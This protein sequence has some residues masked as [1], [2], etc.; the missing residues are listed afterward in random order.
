MGSGYWPGEKRKVCLKIQFQFTLRDFKV[1]TS[2]ADEG[3]KIF[4]M[5]VKLCHGIS[6]CYF[7]AV[8]FLF[9]I[10]MHVKV[11]SMLESEEQAR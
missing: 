3:S 11:Y 6:Q 2:G 7:T 1:Q 4:P 8:D 10:F 5:F 9:S